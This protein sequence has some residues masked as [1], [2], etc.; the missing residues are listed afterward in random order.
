MSNVKMIRTALLVTVL[1]SLQSASATVLTFE[2][3]RQDTYVGVDQDIVHPY[4]Y[5]VDEPNRPSGDYLQGNGWTRNVVV[6]YGTANTAKLL[7]G[8]G[9]GIQGGITVPNGDM[10]TPGPN[11]GFFGLPEWDAWQSNIPNARWWKDP[12]YG[13]TEPNEPETQPAEGTYHCAVMFQSGWSYNNLN[14]TILPSTTY[15]VSMDV[16]TSPTATAGNLS[17]EAYPDDGIAAP[18]Q[19]PALGSASIL[20][21]DVPNT[22]NDWATVS[23]DFTTPASGDPVGQ[24]LYL[25]VVQGDFAAINEWAYVDNVRVSIPPPVNPDSWDRVAMFDFDVAPPAD[26]TWDFTFTPDRGFAV[27]LNSFD[28]DPLGDGGGNQSGTWSVSQDDENGAVIDSGSWNNLA[29]NSVVNVDMS[30]VGG[31]YNGPVVLRLIVTSGDAR[32][33]AIDNIDYDQVSLNCDKGFQLGW[34]LVPDC[35]INLPDFAGLAIVWM[36]CNDPTDPGCVDTWPQ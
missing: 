27:D 30:S 26:P 10:E 33:L 18:G 14:H 23:F 17:I 25:R 22:A 24:N 1:L 2:V 15:T 20:S 29:A 34:D 21:G 8:D 16:R 7:T 32:K 28:L 35:F 3:E 4:G 6:T 11:Y 13:S 36:T 31:S 9:G 12:R 5:R 19:L